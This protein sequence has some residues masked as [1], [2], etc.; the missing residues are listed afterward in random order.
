M[1]PRLLALDLDGTLL[2][3]RGQVRERDRQAIDAVRAD[4]VTVT[5]ITGRLATGSTEAA[6]ACD[7]DGAI[8]CC[9]GSHLYDVGRGATLRHHALPAPTRRALD[10]LLADDDLARYVFSTSRVFCEP[11]GHRFAHYVR[12]WSPDIAELPDLSAA[13]ELWDDHAHLAQLVIGKTAHI[14]ATLAEITRELPEMFAVSFPVA[15]HDDTH[16]MILRSKGPTKGTALLELCEHYGVDPADAVAVGDWI[17]D[18]PMF[19]TA[20][21]SVAMA[22]APPEV[23]A[24][25][26]DVLPDSDHSIADAIER[27]WGRR[28]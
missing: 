15:H 3:P 14:A 23:K 25:A 9:D 5:I 21:R 19:R 28:P 7:I 8:G 10:E 13:D 2:D 12:T 22:V 1:R 27:C 24:A 20:G 11:A 18:V 4:G 16:A 26:T 6:R 17:N